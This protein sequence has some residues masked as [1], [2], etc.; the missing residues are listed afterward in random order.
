MQEKQRPAASKKQSLDLSSNRLRALPHAVGWLPL[1]RLDVS[2]NAALVSPP[3]AVFARGLRAALAYL[4]I[5]GEQRRAAEELV[6]ACC[7][8]LEAALALA[9]GGGGGG[10]G[11][12]SARRV[13]LSVEAA[14]AAAAA[15]AAAGGDGAAA[16]APV[17]DAA[18]ALARLRAARQTGV[19][20][21]ARCR[22][23]RAP[24]ALGAL[25]AALRVVDLSHNKVKGAAGE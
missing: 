21:L 15:A 19:L 5:A 3:K 6:T 18:G 24:E 22:L 9:A 16:A 12:G 23:S 1:R 17:Q 14:T 8:P 10:G 20:A 11:G 4:Q 13:S 7:A 2:G 25:A